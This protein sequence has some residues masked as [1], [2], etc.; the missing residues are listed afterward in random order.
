MNT[1]D[2]ARAI[3]QIMESIKLDGFKE[4]TDQLLADLESNDIEN[5]LKSINELN[6]LNS[7]NF[8][9]IIGK[10]TRGLHNAVSD[11]S[12]PSS[13]NQL[14]NDRTRVDLNY[15]ISLTDEAAQKTLDISERAKLQTQ[16]ALENSQAQVNL[17]ESHLSENQVDETTSKLMRQLVTLSENSVK[18]IHTINSDISD[19]VVAQNFQDI[20]SQSLTK[21][22]NII[23]EV[24]SSLI[25]L[26]QYA[27]LLSKLAQFSGK[28][29]SDVGSE[30]SE[31]LKTNIGQFKGLSEPEHLNQDQVDDLLS[32]LGF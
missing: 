6:D 15:V 11:L 22:L 2:N 29:V 10:L 3:H 17:I 31:N 19:I 24:E 28:E 21:S 13:E 26:T 1:D 14:L 20:A 30:D 27:N 32:S 7:R 18:Q 25:S 12:I 23:K 16:R 8:Y 4:K 9:S 5:A